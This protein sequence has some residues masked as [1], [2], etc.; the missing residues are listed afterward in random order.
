MNDI[1]IDNTKHDGA[2]F[3]L[4]FSCSATPSVKTSLSR[5]FLIAASS[6][7]IECKKH[8]RLLSD[9]GR[10][11][12]TINEKIVCSTINSIILSQAFLE[13]YIN[14]FID[15]NK[16]F[17]S[18]TKERNI[19]IGNNVFDQPIESKYKLA[20][21]TG[22]KCS[23][24]ESDNFKSLISLR[25]YLVHYKSEFIPHPP[26]HNANENPKIYKQLLN[27][28]FYHPYQDLLGF[29]KGYLCFDSAMWAVKTAINKIRELCSCYNIQPEDYITEIERELE[30]HGTT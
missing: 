3:T 22:E 6:A 24:D 27:K 30:T 25:N 28:K 7:T 8:Q 2:S 5:Y 11:D 26:I 23:T 13:S 9:K 15:S 17:H 29:P 1:A 4:G 18:A 12:E 16:K 20:L 14:S 19:T 21:R 10:F